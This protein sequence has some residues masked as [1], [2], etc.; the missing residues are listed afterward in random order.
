MNKRSRQQGELE[1]AVLDVLWDAQPTGLGLSSQQIQDAVND[2][3]DS[4]LALTTVLTVL[5]R[6]SD[7][8]LVERQPASGRGFLFN[9]TTTREQHTA[10]MLLDIVANSDNPALAFSHF[11][12]GLSPEA[13]KALRQALPE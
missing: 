8:G 12:S 2:A 10:A 11:A 1:A 6:L 3:T 4:D 7:K 13:L 9:A 5:T